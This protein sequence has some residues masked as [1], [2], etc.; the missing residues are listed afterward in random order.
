MIDDPT[1]ELLMRL[2]G[3]IVKLEPDS[4]DCQNGY[5]DVFFY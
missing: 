2:M 5:V 4:V 1:V 3:S